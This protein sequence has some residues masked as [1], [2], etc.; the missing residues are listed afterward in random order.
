VLT[1]NIRVDFTRVMDRLHSVIERIGERDSPGRFRKMGVD[2]FFGSGRF[3]DPRTFVLDDT[4]LRGKKFVIA[5]GS[6]LGGRD[7]SWSAALTIDLL[8]NPEFTHPQKE[9]W[10]EPVISTGGI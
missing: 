5:T 7:F 8:R 3:R 1:D 9:G 6:G 10:R 2:V 4:P